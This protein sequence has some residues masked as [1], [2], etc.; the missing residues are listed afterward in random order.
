MILVCLIFGSEYEK[1]TY[2]K[3]KLEDILS[4]DGVPRGG[5]RWYKSAVNNNSFCFCFC[6]SFCFLQV[7]AT[8]PSRIHI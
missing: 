6:G 5:E 1:D 7:Y 4:A 8:E 3:D 2:E